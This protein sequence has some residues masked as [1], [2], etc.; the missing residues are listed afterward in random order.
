MGRSDDAIVIPYAPR[1]QQL[2]IHNGLDAHRFGAVV[3]HR[4]F[5]KTVCAVNHLVR[6]A[7]RCPLQAPRYAYLGPTYGQ[8]KAVAWDMLKHYTQPFGAA[9]SVN[10]TELRVDLPG[11]R[12]IRLFGVE[13]ADSLRGLYLDGVVLDEHGLMDADVWSRIIR[14]ALSDRK[15]WALFI[16]TPDGK[17][18]FYDICE[19]ARKDPEWYY[20]EFKASETGLIDARELADARKSMTAD[21]YAA[22]YECS[23]EV[24]VR[25]AI[26]AQE[27]ATA[28]NDGRIGRW[29][30]DPGLRV[31]TAW[32]LGIGDACAIWFAQ[33]VGN[34]IRLID[35]YEASGAGLDHYAHVL[36][37]R[38]YVYAAHYGP[39]DIAIREFGTG[40]TRLETAARLG[41]KFEVIQRTDDLAEDINAVRLLLPRCYFDDDKAALGLDRLRAW[42]W[43]ENKHGVRVSDE[44]DEASHCGAAFR[45]LANGIKE[46]RQA[47]PKRARGGIAGP[48]AWM[49]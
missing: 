17:N 34:E 49:G 28:R 5:G 12:R 22:E 30:Y 16:G 37:Q 14:P 26:L 48:N 45:T 46:A 27:L 20:G 47:R 21:E 32:D 10:E 2:A 19:Q 43:K 15:G 18:A 13:N 38:G 29:R 1:R 31:Y 3:A 39:H 42:R 24:S 9:R 40:R 44:H 33:L 35:Y 8:A 4:R 7:V 6:A 11:D 23:F 41:I 25:G 36:Q